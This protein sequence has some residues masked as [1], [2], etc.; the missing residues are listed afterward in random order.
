M[1][2]QTDKHESRNLI[3]GEKKRGRGEIDRLTEIKRKNKK[4]CRN[5]ILRKDRDREEI[6]RL[7]K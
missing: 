4:K 1:K 2:K 7:K 6:D 5:V 3:L